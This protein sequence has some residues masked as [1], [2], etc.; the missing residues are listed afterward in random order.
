MSDAT[1]TGM[2]RCKRC[3]EGDSRT[4]RREPMRYPPRSL[5][6]VALAVGAVIC[7][8]PL[9]A[10]FAPTVPFQATIG[11]SASLTGLQLPSVSVQGIG[12][13]LATV[14]STPSLNLNM[15]SALSATLNVAQN[16]VV[17][18][19]GTLS[20]TAPNGDE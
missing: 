6:T 7:A 11:G 8:R 18:Q 10:R 17:I 14:N 1:H 15:T 16:P 20:I 2:R 4:P 13:G 5:V 3:E 19:N 9:M 12:V